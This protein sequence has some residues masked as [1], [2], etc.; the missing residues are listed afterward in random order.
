EQLAQRAAYAVD[1]AQLYAAAR[2]AIGTRDRVLG[3]VA[4][5]LRNP[6]GSM[7]MQAAMLRQPGTEPEQRSEKAAASIERSARRMNRL[8]QDLLD[9]ARMEQHRLS[10][11]RVRLSPDKIIADSV[12]AQ[13]P[14]AEAAELS[15]ERDVVRDLPEVCADRDRLSQIFENL[16]GN[17]IK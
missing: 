10:V 17:A 2:D 5:D 3:I 14:L 13:A 12:E 9:V 11:E 6:L 7:Q 1:N 16:I 15:L 4:H 8:I